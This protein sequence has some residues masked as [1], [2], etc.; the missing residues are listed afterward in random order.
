MENN[1]SSSS[2]S[3]SGVNSSASVNDILQSLHA[4]QQRASADQQRTNQQVATAL[5]QLLTQQAQYQQQQQQIEQQ[6]QQQQQ[7]QQH[8]QYPTTPT[9]TGA[10]SAV[11][12][13][14]APP[15]TNPHVSYSIPPLPPVVA[16]NKTVPPPKPYDGKPYSN[17][18]T[19][20]YYM[21]AYLRANA[22][23]LP[24]EESR[25]D[26]AA[27]HL[28]ESAATWFV[29]LAEFEHT[30]PATWEAFK[31][32]L[33]ERFQPIA[34]TRT[35]RANLRSLQ[36][37]NKSVQEYTDAF[38]KQIQ[39]LPN[40]EEEGKLEAYMV[41]LRPNIEREV[42]LRNPNTLQ[43]AMTYAQGADIRAR[44]RSN[45]NQYGT[46][47][48]NHYS[49]DRYHQYSNSN[50][51]NYNNNYDHGRV[52]TSTTAVNS[53]P[54]ELSN[55]NATNNNSTNNGI[56]YDTE[57][58]KYLQV[59]DL[60]ELGNDRQVNNV[61]DH[62]DADDYKYDDDQEQEEQLAA[63]FGNRNTRFNRRPNGNGNGNGNRVPIAQLNRDEFTRLMK[64]GKC[65]RCKK[66]GHFARN[67]PQPPRTN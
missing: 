19:W 24:D 16:T 38:Y 29:H 34:A 53:T 36:Q 43:E 48:Y 22:A 42:D 28:S 49:R 6:L 9:R 1:S 25:V 35:A 27:A 65:L 11:P 41:G 66:P 63:M 40:M 23:T 30:K 20:C 46:S 26:C 33:K 58:E 60:Y 56:D 37:G 5:Q 10:S 67:C 32:A 62:D 44:N 47:N 18:D 8:Q 31:A 50:S 2:S 52:A 61:N 54:M 7:Q 21:Q 39:L 64:E 15:P 13:T 4:E 17:I 14:Y 55:L 57:Y 59:G 12:R 3:S 45:H 51:R